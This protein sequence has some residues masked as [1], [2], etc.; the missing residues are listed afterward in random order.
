M[1]IAKRSLSALFAI[2]VAFSSVSVAGAAE[3]PSSV[4]QVSTYTLS[5]D[6]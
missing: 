4:N 1:K 6:R 2:S 3:N 5:S